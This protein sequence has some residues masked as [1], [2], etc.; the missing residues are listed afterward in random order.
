MAQEDQSATGMVTTKAGI[1][2]GGAYVPPHE[3]DPDAA[4]IERE[5][6]AARIRRALLDV[7]KPVMLDEPRKGRMFA[8]VVLVSMLFWFCVFQAI[9]GCVA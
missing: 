7:D 9:K 5:R 6:H 8:L 3:A 2:I 1:T 4:R